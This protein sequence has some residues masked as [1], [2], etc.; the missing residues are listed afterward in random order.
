MIT[1]HM[2]MAIT[3]MITVRKIHYINIIGHWFVTVKK[4]IYI[5][6]LDIK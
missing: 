5:Y 4:N 2:N 1:V 6:L 3:I